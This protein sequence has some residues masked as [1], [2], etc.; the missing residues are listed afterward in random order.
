MCNSIKRFYDVIELCN[1]SR[2]FIGLLFIVGFLA[3]SSVIAQFNGEISTSKI[4]NEN[5][6]YGK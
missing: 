2:N 3:V 4:G 6:I 5:K 1:P